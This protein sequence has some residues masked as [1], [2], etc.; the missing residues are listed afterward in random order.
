LRFS[1]ERGK[2]KTYKGFAVLVLRRNSECV[3]WWSEKWSSKCWR[4][5][6]DEDIW[7]FDSVFGKK[8]DG[9]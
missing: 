6:R 5:R 3:V 4:K 8:E 9:T 7:D 2:S 1:W